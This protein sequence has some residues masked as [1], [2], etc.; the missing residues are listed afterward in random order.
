MLATLT[1]TKK[2]IAK[3]LQRF[4]LDTEST[5]IYLL[6]TQKGPQ[7]VLN[8]SRETGIKR[9]Q[10]YR[11]IEEL[12]A[13]QLVSADHLTYGS[14]YQAMPLEQLES[15]IIDK[16]IEV[17]RMRSSLRDLGVLMADFAGKP[18]DNAKV[19]HYSGIEGLKQVSWN[20]TKANHHY[21]VFEVSH[22]SD[23]LDK[24]FAVRCRE[25]FIERGLTS[26]DLTNSTSV[27]TNGIAPFNPS[28]TNYASI[29]KDILDIQFE[30][31]IYNDVVTLLDYSGE[32]IFCMEIY[33]KL[34]NRLA[35]QLFDVAWSQAK[36]I[37]ILD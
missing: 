12:Q 26:Y 3:H 17:Q 36:P 33:H 23:Y 1:D 27:A 37:K 11:L 7:T 21:K 18:T 25:R 20:L 5:R 4:G 2:V 30:V 35:E 32:Q 34:L 8:L 29:S 16:S 31:Y 14:L 9:T 22:L 28:R 24:K 19:L 10:V 13:K 6:L 15:A